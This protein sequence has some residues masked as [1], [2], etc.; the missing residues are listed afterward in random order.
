L[1]L[2]LCFQ[3]GAADTST[4]RQALFFP[5]TRGTMVYVLGRELI[6]FDTTIEQV[7]VCEFR[8][9]SWRLTNALDDILRDAG[10]GSRAVCT[11]L[12]FS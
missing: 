6:F 12:F 2:T 1:I 3:S 9:C 5:H 11:G 4:L 8:L 10:C 7:P